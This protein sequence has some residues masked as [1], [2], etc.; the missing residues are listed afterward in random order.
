MKMV[1][2][3]GWL[4]MVVLMLSACTEPQNV[5][6]GHTPEQRD[7]RMHMY[8][9]LGW[10]MASE[11]EPE[12]W[13]VQDA[14]VV[15]KTDSAIRLSFFGWSQDEDYRFTMACPEQVGRFGRCIL[16]YTMCGWNKGPA[17]WDMTTQI[18]VRDKKTNE[19]YEFS[20]CITPYGGSFPSAWKKTFY[21]DV[22]PL[23]PLLEGETE[24]KIF[25]C[26]WDATDKRAHAV[27]LA[28]YY[29]PGE[30]AFGMPAWHRKVYDS[31]LNG[32]TGYRSWA[33]GIAGH[34]IEADERLGNRTVEIIP[35][36]K[37][38]VLRSCFTGHG[39]DAY[40]AN[41][42][43]PNRPGYRPNNVAEFDENRYVVT[44]N[45][46]KLEQVGRIWELNST[47]YKQAG[48]YW[49]NRAGWGPGKPCNVHYWV[50][51]NIPSDLTELTL[52]MDLWEY[53]SVKTEPNADQVAQFYVEV[54]AYGY[55]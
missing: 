1:R 49:Y 4:L 25:Y 33:Y 24:F 43:F 53:V 5:V 22:T 32:N 52:D 40:V 55:K 44:L 50:I 7:F 38:V 14:E 3:L 51:E 26:G 9:S 42:T 17:E 19:W 39:Q 54:D 41:G 29:I 23:L 28:L 35:G 11:A 8:D 12:Q 46:Q 13:N 10:V 36:T 45:G 48:T 2:M 16:E 20:R 31:T 30:Q 27:R 21:L 6:Y 18:M 15:V 47:N 34:S 37:T